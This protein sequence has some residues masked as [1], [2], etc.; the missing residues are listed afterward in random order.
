MAGREVVVQAAAIDVG[1]AGFARINAL[2]QGGSQGY[3]HISHRHLGAFAVLGEDG[4]FA[5]AT[6]A[7]NAGIDLIAIAGAGGTGF[8]GFNRETAGASA[9]IPAEQPLGSLVLKHHIAAAV[10]PFQPQIGAVGTGETIGAAIF[11]F[12]HKA[13]GAA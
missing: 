4:G 5:V 13:D 8:V 3:V 6:I 2:A 9:V 7:F 10:S 12:H 1:E 11:Q